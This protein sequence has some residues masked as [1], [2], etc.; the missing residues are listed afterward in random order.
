M[1][2]GTPW[3]KVDIGWWDREPGLIGYV[4]DVPNKRHRLFKIDKSGR[5]EVTDFASFDADFQGLNKFAIGRAQFDSGFENPNGHVLF[6]FA[7]YDRALGEEE[8]ME[9]QRAL[10]KR[11]FTT[12]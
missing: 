2:P 1:G 8:M 4:C 12:D 7:V 9:V 11:Y 5:E 6:E 10:F 3:Q